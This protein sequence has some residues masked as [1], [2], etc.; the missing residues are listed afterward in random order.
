MSQLYSCIKSLSV[1]VCVCVC[2]CVALVGIRLGYGM[3]SRPPDM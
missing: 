1:L 2:V 3:C